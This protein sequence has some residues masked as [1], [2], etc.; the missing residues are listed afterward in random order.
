MT[1]HL[2]DGTIHELLDGEVPSA[3][4]PP[5]QAHLA[6]CADCRAQLEAARHLVDFS[7][8]LVELLDDPPVAAPAAVVV[9]PLPTPVR[10]WLRQL[11]WA[12]SIAVAVGAGWYARGDVTRVLPP[13]PVDTPV[14]EAITA[15]APPPPPAPTVGA[16]PPAAPARAVAPAAADRQEVAANTVAEVGQNRVVPT[17]EKPTEAAQAVGRTAP[18]ALAAAPA[19]AA[20]GGGLAIRDAE[21]RRAAPRDQ[22]IT[23]QLIDQVP[24]DTI[25]FTAASEAMGGKLRLIDGLVPLRFERVGRGV[26]VVYRLGTAEVQLI[27]LLVGSDPQVTLQGPPGF[28]A[29]SLAALKRRIRE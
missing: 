25:S 21:A 3:Q 14:A 15:I 9:T 17:M 5:L 26:R 13:V 1:S 18:A 23:K 7:D 24:V 8:E 29:D 12:A 27:Q 16:A 11:A 4:L 28:P 22:V 10:P 2:D 20:S 19:P 6:S